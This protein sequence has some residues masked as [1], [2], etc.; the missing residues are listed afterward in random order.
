MPP[1]AWF[2]TAVAAM[3]GLRVFL[4]GPTLLPDA[5]SLTGLLPIAA[6]IVL[7]VAAVSAFRRL[8]T[9]TAP[10]GRPVALVT[11]GVYRFTRNPMYLGG[12]LVLLGLAVLLGAATPF[13]VPPLY[14]LLAGTR[15]LPPEERVLASAFPAAYEDYRRRTG[16]WL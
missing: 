8:G 14:A 7:N 12:V 4:P 3:V 16:R 5:W 10:E 6:G 13:A 15:F 2:F 9:T 11:D 1:P